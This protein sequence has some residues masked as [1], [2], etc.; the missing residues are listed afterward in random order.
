MSLRYR[1]AG[2]VAEQSH[3]VE[4]GIQCAAFVTADEKRRE[5]IDQIS[6]CLVLGAALRMD[7]QRRA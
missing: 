4:N 2:L 5:R 6:F 7:V 1:R 3:V